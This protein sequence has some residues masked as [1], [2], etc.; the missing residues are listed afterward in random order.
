MRSDKPRLS[1][2]VRTPGTVLFPPP[3]W[4]L[5]SPQGQ[6]VL[7]GDMW[8]CILWPPGLLMGA[9]VAGEPASCTIAFQG[10]AEGSTW[11]REHWVL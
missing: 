5:S 1:P 6:Q 8:L 7:S 10:M 2:G 11:C 4:H 9:P 3:L